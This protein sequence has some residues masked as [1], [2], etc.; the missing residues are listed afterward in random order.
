MRG[1]Q[2]AVNNRDLAN[3]RAIEIRRAGWRNFRK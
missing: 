1:H 2:L 3:F